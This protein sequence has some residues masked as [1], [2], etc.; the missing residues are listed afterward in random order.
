MVADLG[1]IPRITKI[2]GMGYFKE[3]IYTGEPVNAS[4][5]CHMGLVNEV[6]ENK[7]ELLKSARNLC[8]KIT[9]NSPLAVQGAKHVLRYAQDHSTQDTLDFIGLWNTSFLESEDLTESIMAFIQKRPPKYK[10]K[11]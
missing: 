6:H 1:T 7:E 2:I 5:A 3:M 4:R 10:N 8:K 11:L 9:A